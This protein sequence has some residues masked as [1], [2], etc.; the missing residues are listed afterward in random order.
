MN[1]P[2]PDGTPPNLESWATLPLPTAKNT[3]IISWN[4]GDVICSFPC[5]GVLRSDYPAD[6][7]AERLA[8]YRAVSGEEL[9]KSRISSRV[10]EIVALEQEDLAPIV[11]EKRVVLW[12]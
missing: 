4:V 11:L 3:E 8:T 1:K 7:K 2:I 10:Y 9:A 5:L 6:Q 12:V